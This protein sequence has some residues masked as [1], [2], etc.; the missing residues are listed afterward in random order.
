MNGTDDFSDH[1]WTLTGFMDTIHKGGVALWAWSPNQRTAKL[2]SLCQTFWGV[3]DT[4]VDLDTLFMKLHE[5]D[6]EATISNWLASATDPRPYHLDFRIGNDVNARWISARGVGGE[7]GHD[8]EWVQAIF[9]DITDRKRAEDAERLLTAEL[10]HRVANMFSVARALTAIVAREA[11]ST[12]HFAEDLTQRFGVLHE[13]TTLASHANKSNRGN[14][15][16]Q[17]LA[18]R[19]FAPYLTDNKYI[20]I[21][22]SNLVQIKSKDI[23]D[24]AMVF[25]ELAINSAKYGAL[26]GLGTLQLTVYINE[27]A[28]I[29]IWKERVKRVE[30]IKSNGTGFGSRLLKQ[31]I[32]RSLRGSFNRIINESG[33]DIK[34][35]IPCN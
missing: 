18:E 21:D 33:V 10:A 19:I 15:K 25:H 27:K 9:L 31:T 16:L 3:T 6:I 30:P 7:A 4:I 5:D 23:N 11:K 34:I 20:V 8:G 22:I 28:L 29:L 35:I 1:E 17:L 12:P 2:D 13:A 26:A 14:V 32:E 24:C